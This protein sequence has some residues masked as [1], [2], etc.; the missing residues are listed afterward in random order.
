[1]EDFYNSD[2]A[3]SADRKHV[4]SKVRICRLLCERLARNNYDSMLDLEFHGETWDD[5]LER[6]NSGRKIVTCH[7]LGHY[8]DRWGKYE[9]YMMNQDIELLC[10]V[11]QKH[12]FT[13]WD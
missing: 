6:L 2:R 13:W 8:G 1:M 9:S 3:V 5:F 4:A 7:T 10:K 12:I 11:I